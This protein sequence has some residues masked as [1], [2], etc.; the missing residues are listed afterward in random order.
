MF[1]DLGAILF[2]LENKCE[3]CNFKNTF[4]FLK[5]WK[6]NKLNQSRHL[7]DRI[8]NVDE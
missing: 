3:L 7:Q 5:K 2:S 1:I 8:K 4:S 6:K